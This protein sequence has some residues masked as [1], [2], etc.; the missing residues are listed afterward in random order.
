MLTNPQLQFFKEMVFNDQ[1]N[2]RKL[3]QIPESWFEN[4]HFTQQYLNVIEHLKYCPSFIRN[5]KKWVK[6]FILKEENN[7][8]YVGESLKGD[9]EIALVAYCCET[10]EA[11]KYLD[12]KFRDDEDCFDASFYKTNYDRLSWFSER[13]RFDKSCVIKA[14]SSNGGDI[15]YTSDRLK[16]DEEVVRA[17]IQNNGGSF[18][19][20]S[21]RLRSNKD[22]ALLAI[23]VD[24]RAYKYVS[25]D[26]KEDRDIVRQ[27]I[28]GHWTSTAITLLPK[29]VW[30]DPDVV[31][32]LTSADVPQLDF[33]PLA[34]RDNAEFMEG[35]L[36]RIED[37]LS[38]CSERLRGDR[39]FVRKALN[40]GFDNLKF[41]SDELK[42]DEQLIEPFLTQSYN[43]AFKYASERLRSNKSLAL[44][45]LRHNV[46]IFKYLSQELRGDE[47]LVKLAVYGNVNNLKYTDSKYRGDRDFILSVLELGHSGYRMLEFLSDELKADRTIVEKAV[48]LNGDELKYADPKFLDDKSVVLKA[49]DGHGSIFDL[50]SEEMASDPMILSKVAENGGYHELE[51]YEGIYYSRADSLAMITDSYSSYYNWLNYNFMIEKEFIEKAF[52]KSYSL[53]P[54]LPLELR[55]NKE[56]IRLA[57]QFDGEEVLDYIPDECLDEELLEKIAKL[58]YIA[59]LRLRPEVMEQRDKILMLLR[60]SGEHLM[61]LSDA[62]KK[63]KEIVAVAVE[64][65]GLA[66][67]Y[68]DSALRSDQDII[69]LAYQSD[70]DSIL[71]AE[72][73]EELKESLDFLFD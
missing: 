73:S 61:Y 16:D 70:C 45:G 35:F 58:G 2:V 60:Q 20:A 59:I 42:D 41:A 37:C 53:Y 63:D 10:E 39:A 31:E 5:D 13:I 38:D 19:Y 14:L 11:A 40:Y 21:Q 18:K 68:A 55:K 9:K 29:S 67:Q 26:L 27:V 44:K 24:G 3:K 72:I 66:L 48:E 62:L 4:D 52:S 15:K 32:E 8:E 51:N 30:E 12:E 1:D 47:E 49:I 23:K 46:D 54:Y 64:T 7:I 6:F 56:Y 57:L 65:D 34:L 28:R 33:L 17:A 22:L 25:S 36:P 69:R 71:Y 43:S 50:L